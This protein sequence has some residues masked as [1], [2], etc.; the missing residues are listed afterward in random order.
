MP[1]MT[2]RALEMFYMMFLIGHPYCM[3]FRSNVFFV[4]DVA[5]HGDCP[6][7]ASRF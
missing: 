6:S 1:F 7:V 3:A 5:F 2:I 4:T